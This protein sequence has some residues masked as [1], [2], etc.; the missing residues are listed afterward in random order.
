M[1]MKGSFS[2]DYTCVGVRPMGEKRGYSEASFDGSLHLPVFQNIRQL[3]SRLETSL[4]Q[5]GASQLAI[6]DCRNNANEVEVKASQNLL[7]AIEF[8]KG[9]EYIRVLEDM[10]V[11]SCEMLDTATSLDG[12]GS[13]LNWSTSLAIRGLGFALEAGDN[14][15]HG[16]QDPQN[17]EYSGSLWKSSDARPENL[18]NRELVYAC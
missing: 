18:M 15:E 9:S 6:E 1:G 7:V 12:L 3:F 14:I 2:S 17:I 5:L 13:V 10:I 4:I 16:V 11:I 8:D